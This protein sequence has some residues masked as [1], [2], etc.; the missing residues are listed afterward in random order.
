MTS[1]FTHTNS[2]KDVSKESEEITSA[3]VEEVVSVEPVKST[4]TETPE[5][6][7]ELPK[8]DAEN[9]TVL[10]D[11]LPNKPILPWNRYDSPWEESVNEEE[12][13][14]NS[15]ENAAEISE[16]AALKNSTETETGNTV[17]DKTES[18]EVD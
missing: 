4:P 2:E 6:R 15:P 11:K 10:T 18:D 13:G 8:P 7:I 17:T 14:S 9:I 1:K 16:G 5:N 3:S 12:T